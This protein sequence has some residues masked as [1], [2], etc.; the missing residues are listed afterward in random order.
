MKQH[1]DDMGCFFFLE[2]TVLYGSRAGG[3]PAVSAGRLC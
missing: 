3:P 1:S 2:W